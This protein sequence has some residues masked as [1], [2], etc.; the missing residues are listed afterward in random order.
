MATR[1][2]IL[3][4]T[5]MSWVIVTV[6][7][8]SFTSIWRIETRCTVSSAPGPTTSKT[9]KAVRSKIA[10]RSQTLADPQLFSK[11][12][13]KFS[14]WALATAAFRAPADRVMLVS[15]H[16]WDVAGVDARMTAALAGTTNTGVKMRGSYNRVHDSYIEGYTDPAN[17]YLDRVI[18]R[19]R[20]IPI[21]LSITYDPCDAISC[22]CDVRSCMIR[23]EIVTPK[24]R[25]F[26]GTGFQIMCVFG[27]VYT[28][29]LSSMGAI[30]QRYGVAE[31]DADPSDV[32][33]E[34]EVDSTDV[35]EESGRDLT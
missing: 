32:T 34:A 15:A 30:N 8:P 25:G 7:V 14:T 21:T 9:Q 3:K 13:R 6:V 11:N 2:A 17:S 24:T 20:G 26:L 10:A 5:F 22:S 29:D 19:R 16:E 4:A 31:A 28:D 23:S 18:E 27:I 33:E 12:P 35:S 1:S